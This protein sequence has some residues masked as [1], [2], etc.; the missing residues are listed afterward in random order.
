MTLEITGVK[1]T[2]IKLKKCT[3]SYGCGKWKPTDE[4]NRHPTAKD[5]LYTYCRECNV[6]ACAAV[7]LTPQGRAS[8]LWRSA[9]NRA[10]K[11]GLPFTIT[12][13]WVA[14]RVE[15]GV[16]ELTG[17]PIVL[18]AHEWYQVHPSAPS[19]DRIDSSKGYT[20]ENTM[21]VCAA[22]NQIM[23]QYPMEVVRVYC[24]AI[25]NATDGVYDGP[26]ND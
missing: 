25:L 22:E 8:S 2:K 4:F 18:E 16:S 15:R 11:A 21:L 12:R 13:E 3:G 24:R 1:L 10:K 5:G 20:P 9:R 26:C 6:K 23:N 19:L 14:E 7:R 17:M